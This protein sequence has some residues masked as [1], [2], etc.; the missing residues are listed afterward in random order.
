M[1]NVSYEEIALCIAERERERETGERN[2]RENVF[3]S[4]HEKQ[5]K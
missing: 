5:C 1:E 4:S 3:M 2:G